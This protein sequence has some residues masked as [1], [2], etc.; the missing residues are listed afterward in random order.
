MQTWG[1]E[2][3]FLEE[4]GLAWR[5]EKALIISPCRTRSTPI[6]DPTSRFPSRENT[7]LRNAFH[8]ETHQPGLR[9]TQRLRGGSNYP[10]HQN[11]RERG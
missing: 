10:G 2:E 5:R 8:S 11:R 6:A 1:V 9:V 3:E 4:G 7:G